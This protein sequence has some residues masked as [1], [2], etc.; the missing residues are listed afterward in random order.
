MKKLAALLLAV[1]VLALSLAGCGSSNNDGSS[2][3]VKV[4]DIKLTDEE[5]AFGVS[6]NQPELLEKVNEFIAKI[7]SDGTFAEIC[8]T[9]FEGGDPAG[10]TSAK[11]DE[12]KD[13]LV[14]ATNAAFEPFEFMKGDKFFGIDLEIAAKLAEFLGKELVISNMSFDAVLLAVEQGKADIAMAG[15]TITE[16]RKKQVNFSDSYYNASQRIIVMENDNAFDDCKTAEDVE[17]VLSELK[18]GTK[19]GYQNGTT[20]QYYVQGDEVW[21]FD[22]FKNLQG[23]GY[24]SGSLAV[25]DMINGNLKLVII[26]EEPAKSIAKKTNELN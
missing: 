4:I 14:V 13:Q 5:Y 16:D 19:V 3:K 6:K 10:I 23:V 25:Q 20:A 9:Y 7:K 18:E 8:K 1:V 2:K 15:L 21:G 17:K 22:G 24:D 26:D 12:S 11:L